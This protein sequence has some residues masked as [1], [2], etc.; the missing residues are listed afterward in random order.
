[1]EKRASLD[2][3]PLQM[4]SIRCSET[5]V[6]KRHYPL[7]NDP[8]E[9]GSHVLRGGSLKSRRANVNDTRKGKTMHSESKN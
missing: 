5:S 3:W 2:S 4:E 1:V 6:R 7:I 8:E 9:R